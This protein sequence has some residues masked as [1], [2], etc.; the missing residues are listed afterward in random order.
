MDLHGELLLTATRAVGLGRHVVVR[1]APDGGAVT[2]VLSDKGEL[3]APPVVDRG[4]YTL[5]ERAKKNA[6]LPYTVSRADS[7]D[8]AP[9]TWLDLSS[10]L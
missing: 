6:A 3:A 1:I 9:G 2:G 10:C 8:M 5:V 7:L 4:G